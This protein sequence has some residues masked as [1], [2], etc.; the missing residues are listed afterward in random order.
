M[1]TS[2]SPSRQTCYKQAQAMHNKNNNDSLQKLG[3]SECIDAYAINF[4]TGR[5]NL[6]LV[7]KDT[8]SLHGP[9][10]Y[11]NFASAINPRDANC[12][13]DPFDW[14]CGQD[15]AH[16]CLKSGATVCPVAYK[17]IDRKNWS[18]LGNKV[19][20]C[21]S[22][23]LPGHFKVQFSITIAY[24]VIA[25]NACKAA[26]LFSIFFFVSEDP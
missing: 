14:I 21:L 18:P 11:N 24:V 17:S 26:I 19:E 23:K 2:S 4:Q 10:V 9:Q 8:A 5:G 3:A 16:G 25:F 13:S 12:P 22:D 20:Y 1:S 7:T 6:I 15:I